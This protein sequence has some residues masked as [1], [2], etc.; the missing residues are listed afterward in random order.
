MCRQ[1]ESYGLGECLAL[2]ILKA[3]VFGFTVS[4][5]YI[6]A[7]PPLPVPGQLEMEAAPEVDAV[8]LEMGGFPWHSLD[9]HW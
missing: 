6:S 7:A 9:L 4:P 8:P 1:D 2:S 5:G 3:F